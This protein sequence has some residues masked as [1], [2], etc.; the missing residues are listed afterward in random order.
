LVVVAGLPLPDRRERG[1]DAADLQDLRRCAADLVVA[2][3]DFAVVLPSLPAAVLT[4]SLSALWA[5]LRPGEPL[6]RKAVE[7]AVDSVREV[8]REAGVAAEHDVTELHAQH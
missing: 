5:H 1:A 8:L 4:Q 2:G 6:T 3:A 7:A